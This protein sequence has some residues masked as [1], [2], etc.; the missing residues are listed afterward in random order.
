MKKADFFFLA[1]F[2]RMRGQLANVE[3]VCVLLREV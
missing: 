1:D 2:L 3:T